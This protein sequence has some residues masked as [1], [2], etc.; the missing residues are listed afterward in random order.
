MFRG[1][2][3]WWNA[4]DALWLFLPCV[5]A[6]AGGRLR[7]CSLSLCVA[8]GMMVC[9]LLTVSF[10]ISS[11]C[12]RTL[13]A[14]QYNSDCHHFTLTALL[15]LASAILGVGPKLLLSTAHHLIFPACLVACKAKFFHLSN[16]VCG[17]CTG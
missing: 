12:Y 1:W 3:V 13:C 2:Q 11:G 10:A 16:V 5:V 6:A 8:A 7:F 4:Q 9:A 15:N 14:L 17:D